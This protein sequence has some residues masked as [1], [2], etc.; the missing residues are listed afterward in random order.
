MAVKPW[1][2]D[3][4]RSL[5][6]TI[7]R[8]TV[9]RLRSASLN[10]L[11]YANATRCT[12][13]SQPR[14][15]SPLIVLDDSITPRKVYDQPPSSNHIVDV[16]LSTDALARLCPSSAT[17][18]TECIQASTHSGW[19]RLRCLVPARTQCKVPKG[20]PRFYGHDENRLYINRGIGFSLLPLLTLTPECHAGTDI[21]Y[22]STALTPR[23]AVGFQM[24]NIERW[25]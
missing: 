25:M 20:A 7:R 11:R 10:R 15:D 2:Q 16:V 5:R 12:R 14:A 18:R 22:A 6:P 1:C 23:P 3:W 8:T 24:M 4:K 13:T 9:G 19:I 21:L 17:R